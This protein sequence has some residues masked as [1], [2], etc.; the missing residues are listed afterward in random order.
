MQWVATWCNVLPRVAVWRTHVSWVQCVAVCCSVLQ[1]VAVCCSVLPC[2]AV[3]QTHVSWVQCNPHGSPATLFFEKDAT[4]YCAY[5]YI[6]VYMQ[7]FPRKRWYFILCIFICI[8]IYIWLFCS[9]KMLFPIVQDS[10]FFFFFFFFSKGMLFHMLYY[11]ICCIFGTCM[12]RIR[13]MSHT[14]WRRPIGCLKLQ[15]IFCKRATN[16]RAILRKMPCTDEASHGTSPPYM[17]PT[18]RENNFKRDAVSYLACSDHEFV[19]Y[20]RWVIRGGFD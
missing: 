2:V 20:A 14:G 13:P 6:H 17:C 18:T 1:R 3:W 4:S 16:Y 12:C 19:E 11:F 7:L 10:N 8:R 5:S 15:V 9:K